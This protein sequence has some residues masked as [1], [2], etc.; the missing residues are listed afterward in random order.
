MLR[1]PDLTK[2][3]DPKVTKSGSPGGA[4]TIKSV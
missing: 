2:I 3:P 1:T 4:L